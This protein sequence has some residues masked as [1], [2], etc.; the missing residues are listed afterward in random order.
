MENSDIKFITKPDSNRKI[1][2]LPNK[3][4]SM[5]N[6]L[7]TDVTNG[8]SKNSSFKIKVLKY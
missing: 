3:F 7:D 5:F 6:N 8:N 4:Y 1:L 2:P